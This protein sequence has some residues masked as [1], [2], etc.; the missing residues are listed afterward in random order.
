MNYIVLKISKITYSYPTLLY[1]LEFD[2]SSTN[3]NFVLNHEGLNENKVIKFSDKKISEFFTNDKEI[4][5]GIE[6]C[7]KDGNVRA[8]NKLREFN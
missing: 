5:P 6:I 3:Q 2:V 7:C 1:Q 8:S 4:T